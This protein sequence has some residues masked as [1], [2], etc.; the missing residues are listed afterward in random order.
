MLWHKQMKEQTYLKSSVAQICQAEILSTA[1]NQCYPVVRD[2]MSIFRKHDYSCLGHGKDETQTSH[3]TPLFT[4]H[5]P[6]DQ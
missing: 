4:F 2:G 5:L 6:L 1:Q 3:F